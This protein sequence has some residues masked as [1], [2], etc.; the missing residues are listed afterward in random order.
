MSQ[1]DQKILSS[2][3]ALLE[4]GY[5]GIENYQGIVDQ[6]RLRRA[7]LSGNEPGIRNLA[8]RIQDFYS[9]HPVD[10]TG[11]PQG[12]YGI[13]DQHFLRQEEYLPSLALLDPPV[14]AEENALQLEAVSADLFIQILSSLE[15]LDEREEAQV[16]RSQ[17]LLTTLLTAMVLMNPRESIGDHWNNLIQNNIPRS[18]DR[19]FRSYL[20]SNEPLAGMW[21]HLG[22]QY[23]I[24]QPTDLWEQGGALA[25][26]LNTWLSRAGL[27][28]WAGLFRAMEQCRPFPRL[29]QKLRAYPEIGVN[30]GLSGNPQ[31]AALELFRRGD[32]GIAQAGLLSRVNEDIPVEELQELLSSTQDPEYFIDDFIDTLMDQWGPLLHE[33]SDEELAV[34]ASLMPTLENL[35]TR[36][37]IHN[38]LRS[39]NEEMESFSFR[40]HRIFSHLFSGSSL[41]TLGAGV[42]FAEMAPALLMGRL[43]QSTRLGGILAPAG[44][45]GLR[46]TM[47]NGLA[48]GTVLSA[49]GSFLQNQSRENAGFTPHFWRDFGVGAV[50]NGVTMAGA[51]GAAYGLNRFLRPDLSQTMVLGRA[52][53][54]NQVLVRGGSFLTGGSLAWGLG[55]AHRGIHSGHWGTTW[56]E[57]A[58]NYLT[59]AMFEGGHGGLR[60]LRRRASLH[61]ELGLPGSALNRRLGGL[62]VN[63]NLP[64]LGPVRVEQ[65]HH[66]LSHS[67]NRNPALKTHR[68]A[69]LTRLGLAEIFRPG[70]LSLYGARVSQGSTPIWSPKN[71]LLLVTPDSVAEGFPQAPASPRGPLLLP[72]STE[73]VNAPRPADTVLSHEYAFRYVGENVVEGEAPH[74]TLNVGEGQNAQQRVLTRRDFTFLPRED[75]RILSRRG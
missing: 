67:L 37:D 35:T 72:A 61:H 31:E 16:Q 65:V 30:L 1:S 50:V 15:L 46:A 5:E 69:V 28:L 21:S 38:R 40:T 14:I 63:R 64:N 19:R 3:E 44:M 22:N 70:I 49:V 34:L 20:E 17:S 60:Y 75:Q 43:G 57:A 39:W 25:Q 45:L 71:G 74:F 33:G 54:R 58:E 26:S 10:L 12:P 41:A 36:P 51:F 68:D 32:L 13:W 4:S 52:W 66:E 24:S 29:V 48:T 8:G 55:V 11:E 7:I 53:N 27:R 56:D 73:R 6:V 18:F 2:H 42:V 23:N 59:M 9:S 62:L 47:A